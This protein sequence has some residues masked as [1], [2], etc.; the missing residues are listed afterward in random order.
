MPNDIHLERFIAAQ[1]SAYETAL[2]EIRSGKKR[3]HWIWYIFP[4]I[5]GLGSSNTSRYYAITGI[6]EASA[7]LQH[8]LLGKR[9]VEITTA[10]N[11]LPGNDAGAIFSYPDDLKLQSCMTL[12]AAV[13]RAPALFQQVLD[14]F[15]SG[16]KDEQTLQKITNKIP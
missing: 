6:E 10:L 7:F 2:A 14:K 4:Q 3:T 13:A 12:F 5:Q 15:F 11:N 9:L 16:K 1:D 8:P